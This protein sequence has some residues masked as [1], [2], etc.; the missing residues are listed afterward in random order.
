MLKAATS[1]SV[2]FAHCLARIEMRAPASMDLMAVSGRL[3]AM[4]GPAWAPP[5]VVLECMAPMAAH[6]EPEATGTAWVLLMAA[7]ECAAPM[8]VRG[9]LEAMGAA[10]VVPMVA[11]EWGRLTAVIGC[12]VPAICS[13]VWAMAAHAWLAR[14]MVAS[15]MVDPA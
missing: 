10:W 6:G 1:S 13:P 15:I 11:L 14:D 12:A 7:L 3:E 8:V 9:R 5:T 4:E 2:L